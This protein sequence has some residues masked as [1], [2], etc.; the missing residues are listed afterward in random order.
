[1]HRIAEALKFG[2]AALAI[3]GAVLGWTAPAEAGS[4]TGTWRNGMQVGPYGAG[5]YAPYGRYYYGPPRPFGRPIYYG[6]PR[7]YPV[8][9][10]YYVYREEPIYVQPYVGR[11]PPVYEEDIDEEE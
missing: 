5:Y 3:G 6:G 4:G 10:S 7:Y 11:P 9:Q 2:F 1:M 8:P